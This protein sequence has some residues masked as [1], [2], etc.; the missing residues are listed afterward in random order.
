MTLTGLA[1]LLNNQEQSFICSRDY[2]TLLSVY[3]RSQ[4]R[5][6]NDGTQTPWIDENL[7]PFTGD[8]ISRTMLKQRNPSP[9]ERGKDYNHSSF[10][11]LVI[12]GLIGIRPQEGN[13]LEIN[14]LIPEGYWDYFCLKNVPYHGRT[15]CVLYDRTGK[16]YN[17]G[18]GLSVFVDGKK[19]ISSPS[20]KKLSCEL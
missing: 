8:W 4:Y 6:N 18:V 10:C 19:V 12:N 3:A 7:H 20:L 11:D 16:K 17:K 14:P 15:I 2:V 13:R 9:K 5:R 1:N